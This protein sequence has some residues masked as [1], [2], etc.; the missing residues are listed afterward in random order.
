MEAVPRLPMLAFEL[1]HSPEYI[2]FGP[3]LKKVSTQIYRFELDL[4][5]KCISYVVI[6]S[7]PFFLMKQESSFLH[8][9][10]TVP[11]F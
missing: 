9:L 5:L 10:T 2:D 11:D 8:F 6:G 3:T 4:P 7:L 1:K